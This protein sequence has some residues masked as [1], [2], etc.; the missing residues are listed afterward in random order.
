ML[1][2]FT[3]YLTDRTQVKIFYSKC[4]IRRPSRLEAFIACL[5]MT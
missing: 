3:S 5:L 4:T 2:W 1:L